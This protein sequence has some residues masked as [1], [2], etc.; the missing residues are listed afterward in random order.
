M[1]GPVEPPA[2]GD[3]LR[4]GHR[5]FGPGRPVVM[6]VVNR[7]PDSFF[8]RGAGWSEP[9]A[10]ALVGAAVAAGADVVDVG[11]VRAGPGEPVD[12]A[13]EIRR[14]AGFVATVRERHP[15]V[16]VSIDTW[17]HEVAREACAAG[18]GLV[19]DAWGGVDPRTAEVAAAYG[20]GLVCAHTGGLA[21][22]TIAERPA[23]DDVV[24]DVVSA[25]LALAARAEAA[26][27]DPAG[28]LLDPAHD[29][30][31]TTRHS[32]EVTRRLGE[33]VATGRPVLVAVSHKDFVGETL[34][35]PV[36]ERLPG[37]LATLAVCAWLGTRVFRVHDVAAARDV[38][39]M[40]AAIRGD[41]PPRRPVRG[42][43]AADTS[44]DGA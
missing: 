7:T 3:A 39:D 38:V 36:G 37:T 35:R 22:R 27:V 18:A 29:F 17:R 23:Y 26:G 10:L 19:N 43:G 11:G 25:T 5:V 33:L 15:D 2:T 9:T 21:P 34:D 20:A 28:I 24:A 32:L 8:D 6:A 40:V 1:T 13:E 4:L 12:T 41:L 42:L 16:V 31:K 30:G 14:T 44:D